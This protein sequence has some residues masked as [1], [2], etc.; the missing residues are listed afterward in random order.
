METNTI[1]MKYFGETKNHQPI[2]VTHSMPRAIPSLRAR[3][4]FQRQ[5]F[6]F[7]AAVIP[8]SIHLLWVSMMKYH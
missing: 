7:F 1:A 2:H 4:V 3:D 6:I 8:D 5:A